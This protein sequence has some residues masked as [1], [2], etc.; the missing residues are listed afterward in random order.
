M[1][2]V[3]FHGSFGSKTGN[4][5]P[6]LKKE[7][8]TKGHQVFLEQYPVDQWGDIERKGRD[9]TNTTQNLSS[10]VDFFTK[11]TLPRL[12][13]NKEIVF[14]G[15]SLA[16]VFILNLV[17]QFNLQLKGTIF[18]SPF[19]EALNQE[20]T[21]QFDLV[22]RTFYKADFEWLKLKKLIPQSYVLYGTD[23]PY[24]P[25]YFPISFAQKI[26]SE[27]IAVKN[28]GHL[29]DNFREFPLLLDLTKKILV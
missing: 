22:N 10:W 7:L 24:V 19:L 21:W 17:S 6:W 25:N 4:W 15:H 12:D 11:N 18:V 29:G 9:N 14:F 26:G 27:Q 20:H 2:C 8:E 3:I 16:P 1:Q 28:G 23:D 5:F 13:R